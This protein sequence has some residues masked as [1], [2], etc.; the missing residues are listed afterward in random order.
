MLYSHHQSE[1]KKSLIFMSTHLYT[2]SEAFVGDYKMRV[3]K[4]LLHHP[5]SPTY[6]KFG[7]FFTICCSHIIFAISSSENGNELEIKKNIQ[8]LKQ[9]KD[10]I[11]SLF[12]NNNSM[13]KGGHIKIF[14]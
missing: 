10:K 5:S 2:L 1:I 11:H 13:N 8:N 9:K 4:R 7:V 6:F 12:I 14:F 3:G